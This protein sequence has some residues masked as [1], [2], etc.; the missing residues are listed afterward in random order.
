MIIKIDGKRFVFLV[1]ERHRARVIDLEYNPETKMAITT[2]LM[3]V[4]KVRGVKIPGGKRP[5]EI[6][7]SS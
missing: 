6:E 1:T 7:A 4:G 2:T 5:R 3:L